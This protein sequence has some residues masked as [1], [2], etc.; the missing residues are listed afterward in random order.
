ERALATG[1]DFRAEHRLTHKD[2]SQ[3]WW[4]GQGT[5]VEFEGGKPV[6][7]LGAARNITERKR[8]EDDLKR[9]LS[10]L[11]EI[12]SQLEVENVYLREE[13]ERILEFDDIVGKSTALER[14]LRQTEQ[15]SDTSSVVLITGETG[16]GKELIARAIHQRSRRKEHPL[17]VV[18]CAALP[19]TLVESELFGHEKG[20]FTGAISARVGRFER[21]HRGTLFLDEVGEL[22]LELQAK[23]LRVLQ[24][25]EFERLGSTETR[26]V[27]V[28]LIAATNRDLEQEVK[29]G[30]F[31]RDLFYRLHVFPIHVPPLR[32]RREDIPLLVA[33][34]AERKA[35]ALGKR[36]TRIPREVV[37]RLTQYDWP[38]NVREL[39]NVIE[40]AIILAT[41]SVLELDGLPASGPA[42]PVDD[43]ARQDGDS[44]S[45]EQVERAYILRVLAECRWVIRG[46]GAA[47]ERLG[48]H[49]STLYFRMKK[50]G[51]ARPG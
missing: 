17:V 19:S 41:G 23:L 7:W 16:T 47:A 34:V 25:G 20:A 3:S 35:K 26:R 11:Q 18:N 6:R 39:E 24:R 31:R 27:D 49:P 5:P 29:R 14:V 50:L 46:S 13:V 44:Q 38:G 37:E 28:R 43:L 10:E 33:Y 42:R 30:A 9:A 36:V 51:I 40:R 2:G 22:P 4:E 48:L 45:L 1:S 12:K 32:E 21:A 8:A 15:V